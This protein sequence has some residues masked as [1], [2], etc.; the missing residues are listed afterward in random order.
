MTPGERVD[1]AGPGGTR[2]REAELSELLTWA[3]AAE[4]ASARLLTGRARAG[5]TWLAHAL[6]DRLAEDGWS[7][8][9]VTPAPGGAPAGT[10]AAG[11]ATAGRPVGGTRGPA[12][13]AVDGSARDR[14]LI[15]VDDAEWHHDLSDVLADAS[16][17]AGVVRV[18][19]VARRT[20]WWW[21]RLLRVTDPE[22]E[23]LLVGAADAGD[24]RPH[25]VRDGAPGRLPEVG[26]VSADV[27]REV[28]RAVEERLD[29][30]PDDLAAAVDLL[31]DALGAL[32]DD[33]RELTTISGALPY[34]SM[35]LAVTRLE[36]V[37][38]AARAVGPEPDELR[39]A[40]LCDLG[41]ALAETGRAEEALSAD[42]AAAAVWRRLADDDPARYRVRLATELVHVGASC[43]DVGRPEAAFA[44]EEEAVR[45]WR[46]VEEENPGRATVE[47]AKAV[48]NLAVSLGELDRPGDALGPSLEA[49]ALWRGLVAAAPGR[50]EGALA[51]SLTNLGTRYA[52][53]GRADDALPPTEEATELRR[54]LASRSP[55]EHLPDLA[56]SL[57]H[58][59]DR[60]AEAGREAEAA[61][62]FA[63]AVEVQRRLA[64]ENP[65]W[66]GME[67]AHVL[68]RAG[69]LGR[70]GEEPER[71]R[72]AAR[73]AV[74]LYRREAAANPGRF[75]RSLANALHELAL[76]HRSFGDH[77]S[78]INAER[79]AI[80][81]HQ[82]LAATD[83][84]ERAALADSLANLAAIL[85]DVGMAEEALSS[86]VEAA[87]ILRDLAGA[88][89]GRHRRRLAG[90]LQT[91]A[92][93]HHQLADFESARRVRAE[94]RRS[95]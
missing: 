43:S 47:L 5:K 56:D 13:A 85:L 88:D 67:L 36:V 48:S 1:R 94:A 42:R 23:R 41:M 66:Y 17:R 95:S 93:A 62:C 65:G 7:C 44:A 20:G 8:E 60:L 18:L 10:A 28:V 40:T 16:A 35:A 73:E 64:E 46:A 69:A 77:Q 39:A 50:W 31:G 21:D 49:V 52:E 14:V 3:S 27:V 53:L 12:G 29:G 30:D 58:L 92:L 33:V 11:T 57:M 70:E 71:A 2:S 25:P 80:R 26:E 79:E 72:E 83:G 22:V 34:P 61:E 59:G 76:T 38:R 37:E 87:A 4:R 81:V 84:R 55:D 19:L 9:W 45:L 78:A 86:A 51:R 74:M 82:E 90:A 6:A 75:R 68:M 32:P 54:V 63:T 15:V 24:L 89:P 91:L